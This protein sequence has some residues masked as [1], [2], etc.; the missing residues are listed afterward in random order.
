MSESTDTEWVRCDRCR[1]TGEYVEC[2]DDLCHAKGRCMHGN[3]TCKLCRGR[4]RISKELDRRW[5]SRDEFEDVE[6]PDA[7]LR[8]LGVLHEVARDRHDR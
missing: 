8:D 1:G 6:I 2:I 4:G 3:N 5:Y 7:D